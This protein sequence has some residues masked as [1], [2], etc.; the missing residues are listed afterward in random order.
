MSSMQDAFRKMVA[1]DK[2]FGSITPEEF[3]AAAESGQAP[4]CAARLTW[5]DEVAGHQWRLQEARMTL[6]HITIIEAGE[7]GEE[8]EIRAFHAV[9]VEVKDNAPR[10]ETRYVPLD[11]VRQ[12]ENLVDQVMVEVEREFVRS[13]NKLTFYEEHVR[14]H[15]PRLAHVMDVVE[16]E[17]ET[18]E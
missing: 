13:K 12:E 14:A 9:T 8:V 16:A 2:P 4:T 1:A 5:D 17:L 7:E 6:N 3:V 10:K 15:R 11:V 18:K